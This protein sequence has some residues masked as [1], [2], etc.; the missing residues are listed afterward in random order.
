MEP[1]A[2]L[3]GFVGGHALVKVGAAGRKD[4]YA[5]DNIAEGLMFL[6]YRRALGS[7]RDIG[8]QFLGAA[9]EE[10]VDMR[11]VML[12]GGIAQQLGLEVGEELLTGV[13]H[14]A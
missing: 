6:V 9:G 14:L 7:G 11:D 4:S 1:R 8:V 12:G 5:S 10:D 13:A 3:D 2:G